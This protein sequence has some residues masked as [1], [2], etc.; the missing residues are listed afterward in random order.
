MLLSHAHGRHAWSDPCQITHQLVDEEGI[1]IRSA[2]T[3]PFSYK[4]ETTAEY[5]SLAEAFN[6]YVLQVPTYHLLLEL[7]LVA[8]IVTLYFSKS[9]G[10]P[11]KPAEKPTREVSTIARRLVESAYDRYCRTAS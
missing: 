5:L 9:F 1:I 8:G 7:V 2:G 10:P 11:P 6:V 4:M 3:R